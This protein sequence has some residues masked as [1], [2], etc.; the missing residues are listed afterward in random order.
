[1][2]FDSLIFTLDDVRQVRKSVSINIEDFD[3]YAQEA[4]RNYLEKILGVELYTALQNDLINGV[5]QTQ[6]FIDLVDGTQYTYGRPVNYRGVKIYC[7]YLWLYLRMI[8]GDAKDTPIGAMIF[9][10]EHAAHSEG[11]QVNRE[12]TNHYHK[13]AQYMESGIIAFLENNISDYPEF[14]SSLETKQAT[15]E[16]IDFKIVGNSYYPPNN[17]IE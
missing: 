16:N 9:K 4:Q 15:E 13:T 11:K 10:D 8:N 2:S 6:R 5:P 3:Q 7:C 17:F 14:S 12:V 1:M